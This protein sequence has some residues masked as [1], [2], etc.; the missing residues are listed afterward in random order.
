MGEQILKDD[1]MIYT[2]QLTYKD[3][4]F[5]FVFD[6]KELRLIPFKDKRDEINE[7]W[8]R[9]PL[10]NGAYT[11]NTPVME[12]DY[13]YGICNE[14]NQ[15]IIFLIRR[16][17]YLTPHG[18]HLLGGNYVLVTNVI[19]YILCKYDRKSI[20]R[21]SFLCPEIDAIYPLQNSFTFSLGAYFEEFNKTGIV[22]ITTKDFDSTTSEPQ[23]F[24]VDNRTVSV[25]FSVCVGSI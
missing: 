9:T 11:L 2:G 19:A 5:T 25:Y 17:D 8:L 21:I 4:D 20:D 14:T 12:E 22:S 6:G 24:I 7:N 10:V 16:S 1:R 3:M 23:K 13:L 18:N 15:K